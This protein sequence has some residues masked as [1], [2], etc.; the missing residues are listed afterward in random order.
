MDHLQTV[1]QIIIKIPEAHGQ[2]RCLGC[3]LVTSHTQEMHV[4]LASDL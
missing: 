2:N 1:F 4:V 3:A